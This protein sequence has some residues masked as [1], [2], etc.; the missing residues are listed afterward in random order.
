MAINVKECVFLL[1]T[2]P[3]GGI[4]DQIHVLLREVAMVGAVR[5]TVV[6]VSFRENQDIVAA[7][8]GILEDGGGTKVH[9]RIMARGLI[10]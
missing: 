4:L 6:V 1:K 10:R 2:E 8:E 3:W 9:I 5:G 7:T